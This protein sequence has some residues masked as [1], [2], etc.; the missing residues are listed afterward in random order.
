MLCK[1]LH[2]FMDFPIWRLKIAS[3][4]ELAESYGHFFPGWSKSKWIDLE[5]EKSDGPLVFFSGKVCVET[6]RKKLFGDRNSSRK[7]FLTPLCFFVAHFAWNPWSPTW[8]AWYCMTSLFITK[9]WIFTY[10]LNSIFQKFPNLY[11]N[12][13]VL[14][15]TLLIPFWTSA[16]YMKTVL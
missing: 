11:M 3:F 14:T 15:Q 13:V 6:F 12:R 2:I 10:K 7:Y 1:W 8:K 5:D 9:F 16:L 4:V